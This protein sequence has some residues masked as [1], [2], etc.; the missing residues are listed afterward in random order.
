MARRAAASGPVPS[1]A[2]AS[3]PPTYGGKRLGG[4]DSDESWLG[5]FLRE[6][7]F[8]PQYVQGNFNILVSVGMFAGGVFALRKWGDGLLMGL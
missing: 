4:P 5:S 8:H 1:F 6:Q 2:S 7:I 3:G